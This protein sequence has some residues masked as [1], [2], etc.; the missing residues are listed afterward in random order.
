MKTAKRTSDNARVVAKVGLVLLIIFFYSAKKSFSQNW[1]DVWQSSTNFY[2]IQN[3]FNAYCKEHENDKKERGEEEGEDEGKF[4]G[5]IQFKR[6][7]AYVAPRVYPS[8]DLTL[9]GTT[10]NNY[11]EFLDQYR[12]ERQLNDN[13][14]Q[15]GNWTAM[16]P[17]GNLSGN[18]TNGLP[19]KAGRINFITFLPGSPNTYWVGAPAGG[20]WKTTDNGTTWSTNTDNLPVIGCTDLAIDPTNN[21]IMYLAT[22]DGYGSFS[23]P[24]SIGVWKSIDGGNTF[25]P[26]GLVFPIYPKVEMRR[27]IINPV[28][29]NIVMCSTSSG[30]YR[31]TTGGVGNWTQV[32]ATNTY[33]LEFKPTN[34][35]TVYAGG[36]R[37]RRSTDGGA[38]WTQISNGIPTSGSQRM[39]IAT[40]V[41]N[42]NLVYVVS[43]NNTNYGLQGVYRSL[44]AGTSFT[45]MASTP[46]LIGNDCYF[47]NAVG[48][49][50]WYDLAVDASPLNANEITMGGLGVWRSTNGGTAWTNIGCA[51]N[52][53]STVP[54]VHT[55][56]QEIEYTSTGI[57]YDVN[58]G[59]VT[60]YT[61][62]SWTDHS[63]PMNIAQMYKIGTSSLSA[64]YWITGH[65]DNGSNIFYNGVYSA[66]LAADGTD[67]FIDRTNDAV[68]YAAI[69]TGNF[70]KSLNGGGSWNQCTTGLPVGGFVTTWKQDPQVPATLYAGF[71]QMYKSINGAGNWN[72]TPGTM[73]PVLGNEYITEFAIAPS[74]DQYIYAIH[75]TTGVFTTQNAGATNWTLSNTGLPSPMIAGSFITVDP[76]NPLIAWVTFSGYTAGKKVY[77]TIDGGISW[78][79]I[80][81]NLPNLPANCSVYETGNVNGR[82]Y[83]GMEVGVYY[84]DFNS[85]S[86]TLFNSGLPNTPVMDMEISPVGPAKI[87]AATFGRGVYELDLSGPT[88]VA[89]VS[90]GNLQFT[91][92][93][94]PTT[95]I[96]NIS[97]LTQEESDLEFEITNVAGM[98]VFQKTERF[99]LN[100]FEQ[101]LN[102][103]S[104]PAGI[105]F[106]SVS[107]KQGR[108]RSVKIVKH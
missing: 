65:Q 49:Q 33:D 43:A 92:Y 84:I 6:W 93:P 44:D 36:L 106:F 86:W 12:S 50:G 66:S 83:V 13:T 104:F 27:I 23:N 52:W 89:P 39:E 29:P 61:G 53:N 60:Q 59:G 97:V 5:Y 1:I 108:S 48:G 81:Y 46:N 90:C 22:G 73:T 55:D 38:T 88:Q 75:G 107:S 57:M 2:A 70:N 9:L 78:Q 98:I 56:H 91:V 67:C 58:D 85:N 96:L 51:Y 21:L 34:P 47:T 64:N 87:R 32:L 80:S 20:L 25:A 26:T 54:Y 35:D 3:A 74:N 102:I 10:W 11:K 30:V 82:L 63:N 28:N 17:F 95:D 15:S 42:P 41:A 105:Y 14:I 69:S 40:T 45:L 68:M 16:G 99:G 100:S 31:T 37:F 4:P 101:Q 71:A 19:R 18:A 24:S 76:A 94:N 7:E 79:N 8:G 103:S 62:N 77:R 72:A